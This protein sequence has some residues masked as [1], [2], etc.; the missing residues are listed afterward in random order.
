MSGAALAWASFVAAL[1][2]FVGSHFLPAA[3]GAREALVARF[4]RRAY[5]SGYGLVSLALLAWLVVAA[6][7]APYVELWPAAPWLRWVPNVIMPAVFVLAACGVGAA[8]PFALGSRRGAA[9]DPADPGFAAVARHPLLLALALW[10][11]AHA[12]ANGDLAH[13]ALFGLFLAMAVL[14]M[15]AADRRAARTLGPGAAAFFAATATLSL[16]PFADAG[17]RARNLRRLWPR[18]AAGLALWLA[19]LHLHGPAIGVS[20]LPL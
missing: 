16:R 20:P 1:A 9:F 15:A 19:A 18:A 14:A 11:G 6:R 8:Q 3:T 7:D 4:G 2:A 5:F 13:V 10:A 12:A 17:W